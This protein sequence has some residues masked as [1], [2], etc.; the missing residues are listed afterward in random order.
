MANVHPTAV[1]SPGAVLHESVRI[2][3]YCII[4]SDVVLGE[5]TRCHAHV[6]IDGRTTIGRHC[7]IF[8]FASIG[9]VPQDL[10]FNGEPTTLVI[11][12]HNTIREHV[13]MNIGTSQDNGTTVVGSHCLFMMGSHVAHDCIVGDHV[14][15]ANNA[16]LAGHVTVG[17]HAI[18]GGL[19]AV[20]QFV[21][22]GRYAMIGGGTAV[23]SDIAPFSVAKSDRAKLAGLNL[24]GLRRAGFK[25]SDIQQVKKAYQDLLLNKTEQVIEI[26][27]RLTAAYPHNI[28]IKEL[29]EFVLAK[30]KRGFV[31][32]I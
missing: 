12:D 3:P 15:M 22:V 24:V 4:G 21:R 13:T 31:K 20:H 2:G 27:K 6:N 25:N 23:P 19:S 9:T 18:L 1:I 26:T 5:G 30:S 10:K 28:M 29:C 16:T 8:P 32:P 14:I 17:E 7:E 11:G